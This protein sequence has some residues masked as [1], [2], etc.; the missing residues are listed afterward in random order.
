MPSAWNLGLFIQRRVGWIPALSLLL[1]LAGVLA[2][3]WSAQ[4][5]ATVPRAAVDGPKGPAVRQ[6]PPAPRWQTFVGKLPEPSSLGEDLHRVFKLATEHGVQLGRGEYQLQRDAQAQVT[7]FVASFP[8][9]DSYG[10]TR[11]FIAGVLNG[12]PHVALDEL[13]MERNA[14]DQGDV[15]ARMKFS[16]MYRERP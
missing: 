2:L 7:M 14:A 8:I 5:P 4:A 15:G 11:G 9:T 13:T 10:H 12:M 3:L 16:F 6:V 1:G